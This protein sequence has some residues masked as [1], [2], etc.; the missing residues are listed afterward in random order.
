MPKSYPGNI[1][2]TFIRQG[3]SLARGTTIDG[4]LTEEDAQLLYKNWRDRW[5]KPLEFQGGVTAITCEMVLDLPEK[6]LKAVYGKEA[7][8]R[9]IDAAKRNV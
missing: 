8:Q 1:T 7:A 5:E 6:E 4:Y 3:A 9:I 2:S